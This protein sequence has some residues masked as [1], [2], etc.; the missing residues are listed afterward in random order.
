MATSGAIGALYIQSDI[1]TTFTNEA[2]TTNANYTIYKITNAVKRYWDKNTAIVVKKNGTTITS[3]FNIEYAGGRIVFTTP[4][5]ITD[6]I[7]VSGKYIPVSQSAGIF[8]WTLD[9]ETELAD[10]TTFASNG[11]KEFLSTIN[12]YTVSADG[13]YGD[14][15]FFNNLSKEIVIVLY[16]NATGDDRYEGFGIVNSSSIEVNFD[17][18]INELIEI[19]GVGQIYYRED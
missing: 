13:Y 16:V 1:P 4:N 17:G 11:N 12:S 2:T 14:E 3:G 9:S 7:T 19:T 5:I 18:V 8:N 15:T 10:V 6:A